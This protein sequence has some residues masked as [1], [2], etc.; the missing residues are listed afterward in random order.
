MSSQSAGAEDGTPPFT[1]GGRSSR[2]DGGAPVRPRQE[3]ER[4]HEALCGPVQASASQGR[5]RG[6][7]SSVR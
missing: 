3:E 4:A 5:A 7:D 6:R 2:A 1:R